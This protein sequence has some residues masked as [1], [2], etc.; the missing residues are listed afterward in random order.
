[1]YELQRDRRVCSI[2]SLLR[3]CTVTKAFPLYREYRKSIY[4]RYSHVS[5]AI[6]DFRRLFEIVLSPAES[7]HVLMAVED[8]GKVKQ[9]ASPAGSTPE[10]EILIRSFPCSF[11]VN[12]S[13]SGLLEIAVSRLKLKSNPSEVIRLEKLSV[14]IEQPMTTH[15]SRRVFN[16]LWIDWL[17][18][19]DLSWHGAYQSREWIWSVKL[20]DETFMTWI[21]NV[22]NGF[23]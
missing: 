18:H 19:F 16:Y 6:M 20:S 22:K 10:L 13:R 14:K 3:C 8:F 4:P 9:P 2:G 5:R 11:P 1:M 21:M 7:R 23:V 17:N 12:L 15:D